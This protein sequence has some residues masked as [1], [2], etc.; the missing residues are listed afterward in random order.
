MNECFS[1]ALS[2]LK[3]YRLKVIR[4]V[5]FLLDNNQQQF[6]IRSNTV[7]DAPSFASP[8]LTQSFSG[9]KFGC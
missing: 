3:F 8:L 5:S 7:T 2:E 1:L 4:E 6:V 9:T